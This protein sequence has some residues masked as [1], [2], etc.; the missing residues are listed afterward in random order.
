M[1][2]ISYTQEMGRTR[3]GFCAHEP[4]SVL[5]SIMTWTPNTTKGSTE[6]EH[7]SARRQCGGNPG[8]RTR[9]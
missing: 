1:K 8:E 3:K 4:H 6:G 2:P 9:G 5:L 7:S